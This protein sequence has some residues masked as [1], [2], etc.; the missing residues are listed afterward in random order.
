[1]NKTFLLD[2]LKFICDR[3]YAFNIDFYVVGALGGYIDCNL[4]IIRQYDDIDIMI[5]ESDIEKLNEC[6]TFIFT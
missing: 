6:N 2:Q 5:L 4:E 3:L 1:M